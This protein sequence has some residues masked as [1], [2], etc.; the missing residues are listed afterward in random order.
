MAKPKPVAPQPVAVK[1]P[2]KVA[3]PTKAAVPSSASS[4]ELKSLQ[5]ENQ[6]LQGQVYMAD[7]SMKRWGGLG[8]ICS[9]PSD[10]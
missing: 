5:E 6:R 4:G 2:P 8:L 7:R 3:A 10:C 1:A 9:C